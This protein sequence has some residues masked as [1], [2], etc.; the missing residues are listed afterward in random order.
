[1]HINKLIDGCNDNFNKIITL[2]DFLKNVKELDYLS[3]SAKTKINIAVKED[4][5]K[6]KNNLI[7]WVSSICQDVIE[8]NSLTIGDK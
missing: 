8:N 3:E 1:M 6:I 7:G 5:L 2:S 4:S